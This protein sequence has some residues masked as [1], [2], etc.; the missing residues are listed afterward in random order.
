[1]HLNDL[2]RAHSL[3]KKGSILFFAILITCISTFQSSAEVNAV[4]G[5]KLFKQY[6]TSCHKPAPFDTKLVGPAL[7]DIEKKQTEEWLIKWIRN[8]GALRASG[9]KAA[10]DIWTEYGKNEMPSFLSFS[11][12]DIK[13]ILA[14]IANPPAAP[15]AQQPAAGPGGEPSQST[16]VWLYLVVIAL[17]VVLLMLFRANKALKRMSME[18]DGHHLEEET[19]WRK[20]LTSTKAWFLYGLILVF[21]AGWTI[22]DSAIRLG[23]SKSIHLFN[24]SNSHMIFT[25][26]HYRSIVFI[27]MPVQKK[28]R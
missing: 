10:I 28:V 27:A 23:H 11:D 20:R 16:S 12:D 5:E 17:I 7:K 9:D 22:T 3:L 8:N 4:S 19:P 6:C 14:Y 26:V 24:Q 13:S 18:K 15:V 2:R 1:M 21:L 25:P